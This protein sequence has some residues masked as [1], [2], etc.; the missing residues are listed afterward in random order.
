[1]SKQF[2]NKDEM[3]RWFRAKEIETV[4]NSKNEEEFLH[5]MMGCAISTDEYIKMLTEEGYTDLNNLT[6]NGEGYTLGGYANNGWVYVDNANLRHCIESGIEVRDRSGKVLNNEEIEEF[7]IKQCN[8]LEAAKLYIIENKKGRLIDAGV[9]IE[10]VME[11]RISFTGNRTQSEI[12]NECKKAFIK[13]IDE[14]P[15]KG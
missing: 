7:I 10:E 8:P 2:K 3:D 4:D 14:Q 13:M 6:A 9:L 15:T 1:M 12:I 5:S 11:W